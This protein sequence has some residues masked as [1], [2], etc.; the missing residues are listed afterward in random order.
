MEDEK[1]VDM[2]GFAEELQNAL[3]NAD[4]KEEI[5]EDV[6]EEDSETEPESSETEPESSE[7][8][9]EDS[10]TEDEDSETEQDE[11][12]E[13]PLIPN[14]WTAEEKE[15]FEAILANPELEKSAKLMIDRY[16]NLKKG[17]YKKAIELAHSK[18]DI[19]EW[20]DIFD[21]FKENLK[22]RGETPTGYVAKLL[23]VDRQLSQDAP[24]VIKQLMEAYRVTPEKLGFGNE[25]D[26]YY[27]DDKI[28]R[29]EKKIEMLEGRGQQDKEATERQIEK[30]NAEAIRA[31]KFAIDE[32]GNDKYP[33][34][35]EVKE[36]MAILLSKG[37]ANSL[38]DAYYKSPSVKE[39]LSEENKAKQEKEALAAARKKAAQVKKTN[40]NPRPNASASYTGQDTR[41]IRDLLAENF[42]NAGF[43]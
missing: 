18:K 22:Q 38:E 6:K 2:S 30:A 43:L 5:V 17:F 26:D 21:P 4:K 42:K 28:S 19:S 11:K 33:L 3:D 16:D 8:E 34:F 1:G 9:D 25:A 15:E 14:E 20:N 13:F 40:K 36:E 35:E 39:K 41:D 12:D 7:T 32:S 37:K 31:F 10:E 24:K 27:D 29:L 23:N